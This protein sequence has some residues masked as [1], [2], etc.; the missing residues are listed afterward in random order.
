MRVN[1]KELAEIAIHEGYVLPGMGA[2]LVAGTVKGFLDCALYQVKKYRL[3][4]KI[5]DGFTIFRL[6]D[7]IIIKRSKAWRDAI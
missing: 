7:K 2:S 3:T 1:A 5:N 4:V 6:G